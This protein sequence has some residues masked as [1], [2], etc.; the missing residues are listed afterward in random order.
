M[1]QN[2]GRNNMRKYFWAAGL[3]GVAV[4]AVIIVFTNL[5]VLAGGNS[6]I[7]SGFSG[8]WNTAIVFGGG[9]NKDG[10]STNMQTER[11]ATGV[12]LYKGHKVRKLMFT[13][14]D[15]A[16][17]G[18]EVKSMKTQAMAAEVPEQDIMVDPHG[19][20]TYASCYR[21]HAV[22]GLDNFVVVS[23]R[24]HLPRIIYLCKFL[25]STSSTVHDIIGISAA[26]GGGAA[27]S[28]ARE[29]LTRVKA[30]WQL[31]V[32]RPKPRSLER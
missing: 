9:V 18:D 23:Q 22:Y 15:G 6:G 11:V 1:R 10:S 24:F 28:K 26:D 31:E 12:A 13:G 25:N 29:V 8:T 7:V 4:L 17:R 14:D 32:T 5:K 2:D 21:A 20:N 27:W 19:Y 16:L 30:W 3:S